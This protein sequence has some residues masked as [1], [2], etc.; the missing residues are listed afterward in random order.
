MVKLDPPKP[1]PKKPIHT[2]KIVKK[3]AFNIDTKKLLVP[4]NR[5]DDPVAKPKFEYQ[6]PYKKKKAAL[7]NS[8]PINLQE[9]KDLFFRTFQNPV[10]QYTNDTLASRCRQ[11]FKEPSSTYL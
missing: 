6:S 10:F 4:R 7:S 11:Q 1:L 8:M 5:F 9:Q 3:K 2:V